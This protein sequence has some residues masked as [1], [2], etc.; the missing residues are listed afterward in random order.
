V[1]GLDL[2]SVLFCCGAVRLLDVW[3]LLAAALILTLGC[4]MIALFD[5]TQLVFHFHV[6][7]M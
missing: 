7:G 5:G 3:A 1:T 6:G 4:F 2:G